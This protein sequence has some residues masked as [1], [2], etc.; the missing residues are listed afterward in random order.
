VAA[1]VAATAVA[2]SAVV[3]DRHSSGH[4]QPRELE[5]RTV[6]VE[7]DPTSG[8][9]RCPRAR[10]VFSGVLLTNGS[11]GVV[12]LQWMRPD[13]GTTAARSVRVSDGQTEVRAELTFSVRGS[14][15]LAGEAE[16]RVLSPEDVSA[17]AA[18]RYTCPGS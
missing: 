17:K 7:V 10:F 18:V 2:T 13:G 3:W 16:L 1:F 6:G 8:I 15:P 9:G 4:P 12:R 5:V 14:K 11:P